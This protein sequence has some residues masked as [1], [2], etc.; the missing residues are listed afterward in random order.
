MFRP[1]TCARQICIFYNLSEDECAII[2]KNI[3]QLTERGHVCELTYGFDAFEFLLKWLVGL[4]NEKYNF[5]D[6][7]VLAHE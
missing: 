1:E 4:L 7:F 6:R 5:N 2:Y 3:S